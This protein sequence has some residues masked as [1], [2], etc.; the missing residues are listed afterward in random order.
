M[1]GTSFG[2]C[3]GDQAPYVLHWF[4]RNPLQSSS[5][6]CRFE[7]CLVHAPWKRAEDLVCE[8]DAFEER[9]GEIR[10]VPYIPSF[11]TEEVHSQ[12][13]TQEQEY[14]PGS[15]LVGIARHTYLPT[16]AN[17]RH[18]Y[19]KWRRK[20]KLKMSI[21]QMNRNRCSERQLRTSDVESITSS[22]L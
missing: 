10:G 6:G 14:V 22:Q 11:A 13:S 1:S 4:Y 12:H 17:A 21:A 9:C 2:T 16:G 7:Q 3:T 15:P 20:R 19:L 18:I 8:P 5:G